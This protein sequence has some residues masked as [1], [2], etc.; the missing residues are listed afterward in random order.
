MLQFEG[1]NLNNENILPP[2]VMWFNDGR[3]ICSGSLFWTV[4]FALSGSVQLLTQHNN[5]SIVAYPA[6]IDKVMFL[7]SLEEAWNDSQSVYSLTV[8]L[9]HFSH[10]AKHPYLRDWKWDP[11]I[12]CLPTVVPKLMW[13]SVL[14]TRTCWGW[15]ST[16]TFCDLK[17]HVCFSNHHS[18]SLLGQRKICV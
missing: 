18:W 5:L 16:F 17:R 7:T 11:T 1:M 8:W 9:R 3:L 14:M 2:A 6:Q 13:R 15:K 12:S 4:H 10:A